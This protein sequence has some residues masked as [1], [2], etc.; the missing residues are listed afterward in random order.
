MRILHLYFW[1]ISIFYSAFTFS[2]SVSVER[3]G[4]NVLYQGIEN[5]VSVAVENHRCSE[6]LVKAEHGKIEK[7]EEDCSYKYKIEDCS[8]NSTK[9]FVG[10]KNG[11]SINWIDTL[12]HRI[13]HLPTPG[14]YIAGVFDQDSI[15]K[16]RI[17]A[18]YKVSTMWINCGPN[19]QFDVRSFHVE[20]RRN[21]KV[22]YERNVEGARI[23]DELKTEFKK[24]QKDDIV[25][26]TEI[27]TKK[28]EEFC[29]QP[30]SIQIT[31]K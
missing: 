14:P 22:T 25:Y 10:V 12:E 3:E 9:I 6:I 17:L 27:K 26:F 13:K 11:N 30:N 21:K 8:I 29:W 23:D 16:N 2:Q 1:L 20:I 19:V 18:A 24:L 28:D 5:P 15:E 7:S 4:M 31:L